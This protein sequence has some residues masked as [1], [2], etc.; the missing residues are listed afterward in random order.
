M[1][2]CKKSSHSEL[3]SSGRVSSPSS[4]LMRCVLFLTLCGLL[5]V[6]LVRTISTMV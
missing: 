5:L 2:A 3:S 4:P 1:K 6:L